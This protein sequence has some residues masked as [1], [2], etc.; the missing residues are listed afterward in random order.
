MLRI[1]RKRICLAAALALLVIASSDAAL[2][3]DEHGSIAWTTRPRLLIAL[4]L[5]AA[6]YGRGLFVLWRRAGIG[7]GVSRVRA[8]SYATGW[9]V[10]VIALASP[11]DGLAELLAS[12]HMVQHLL[13]MLVAAPLM[14]VGM[15]GLVGLWALPARWRR[16]VAHRWRNSDAIRSSWEII[17]QPMLAWVIYFAI[18]WAWHLPSLYEAALSD[19]LIHDLQHILFFGAAGLLWWVMLNPASQKSALSTGVLSL[20]TTALHAM[21][22]GVFMTLSPRAWYP[23]YEA[24]TQSWGLTLLE[25]QQ[26]A[27]ALM[28][29]PACIVYVILAASIFAFWLRETE[30]DT[31]RIERVAATFFGAE[32]EANEYLVAA[33]D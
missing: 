6:I 28:W 33:E 4:F 32:A 1:E 18:L 15:P 12:A 19:P 2:A 10:L 23:A 17:S 8:A 11:L 20:F 30:R 13:L 5:L 27:G 14:I 26:I 16:R 22:L 3:H 25:D 31:T 29:M 24:T 21:A 9:T 7:A